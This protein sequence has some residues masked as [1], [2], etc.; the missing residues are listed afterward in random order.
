MILN[1]NNYSGNE[2]IGQI[3]T[4]NYIAKFMVNNVLKFLG[5][6]KKKPCDLKVLEPSA[7]EG[8]LLKYLEQ[9]YVKVSTK[10]YEIVYNIIYNTSIYKSSQ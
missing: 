7:G 5:D 3:Y 1:E 10:I 2:S 8:I 9:I 4:P 6:I